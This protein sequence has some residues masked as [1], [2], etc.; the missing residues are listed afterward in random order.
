MASHGTGSSPPSTKPS[1]DSPTT[2]GYSSGN[3]PK[4]HGTPSSSGHSKHG[5]TQSAP[6][7]KSKTLHAPSKSAPAR[8][9]SHTVSKTL[10]EKGKGVAAHS[11]SSKS[12]SYHSF[13]FSSGA[14]TSSQHKRES[15]AATNQAG[16]QERNLASR[17]ASSG[18][19]GASIDSILRRGPMSPTS[20]FPSAIRRD[21]AKSS[22]A[23]ARRAL[24]ALSRA[25]R[26]RL[27]KRGGCCTKPKSSGSGKYAST[28]STG[29]SFQGDT[30]KPTP[31]MSSYRGSSAHSQH[32]KTP[33]PKSTHSDRTSNRYPSH[34]RT[35]SAPRGLSSVENRGLLKKRRAL[36]N[37]APGNNNKE[38]ARI[39]EAFHRPSARSPSA[40]DTKRHNQPRDLGLVDEPSGLL[41]QRGL[42]SKLKGCFG[43]GCS[44]APKT[45]ESSSHSDWAPV[46]HVFRKTSLSTTT[47]EGSPSRHSSPRVSLPAS[48]VSSASKASS[49][50]SS[51]W[52]TATHAFHGKTPSPSSH[53]SS[54]S[55]R[56]AP[57]RSH[58]MPR[59]VG[60]DERRDG[61]L[62]Q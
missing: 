7:H 58:S 57:S 51:G 33:S 47:S 6:P 56:S 34:A 21:S 48:P 50:G 10:D 32:V 11:P 19:E 23:A 38:Q 31:P 1:L 60:G 8:L 24:T 40:A 16:G 4:G 46:K 20:S 42:G 27:T 54:S 5:S 30:P 36:R 22:L 53:G 59:D 52:H 44:K 26:Q 37:N 43:A 49:L 61:N 14:S 35:H 25:V 17:T 13:S 29:I 41:S 62:V 28:T 9:A 15:V 39:K 18:N 12:T 45:P 3:N 55:G 2:W